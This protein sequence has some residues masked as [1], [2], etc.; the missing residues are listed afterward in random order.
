MG[1]TTLHGK[2]R[3]KRHVPLLEVRG[4]FE[5]IARVFRLA[6]FPLGNLDE[7]RRRSNE[8]MKGTNGAKFHAGVVVA[9]Y[10]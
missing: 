7:T 10:Q 2:T 4:D 1:R 6:R 9:D 5:R 3:R 8:K